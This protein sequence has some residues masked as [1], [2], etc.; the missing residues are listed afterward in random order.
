MADTKISALTLGA[1]IA[2]TDEFASNEGG[3][4]KKKTA[5]QIADFIGDTIRNAST[6]D[7]T[8]S[9]ATAYVTNSNL[10]VPAGKVRIGTVFRWRL[11]ITK[12]AAGTTAGC[13]V[14]VKLGTA[15]TT[16]D[17]SVLTFTF[18][19]PT[20]AVD[21]AFIDVEV[22]VRGP[23][24]ASGILAGI[25]RMTHNLAATGFSTLPGE[26]ISVVSG[27]FDVT[28]A[29]LIAGLT[30]TTTTASAWTVKQVTAEAKYL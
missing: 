12:T 30:I 3:T 18:G 2:A 26:A 15:G 25:A 27:V 19:T 13:V 10:A 22:T 17:T 29:N 21:T 28:T 9:A 23:L 24:S 8:I 7:Q 16:A 14:I 20:A 11:A 5:Q 6:A 4:S 1:A